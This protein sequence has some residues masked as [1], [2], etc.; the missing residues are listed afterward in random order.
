MIEVCEQAKIQTYNSCIPEQTSIER[1]ISLVVESN[2]QKKVV[3]TINTL[4]M[5]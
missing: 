5:I 1:Q 4:C 2:D 3:Q